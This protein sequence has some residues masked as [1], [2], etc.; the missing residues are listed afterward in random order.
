MRKRVAIAIPLLAPT[1]ESK[2]WED[3]GNVADFTK[4]LLINTAV[5][6]L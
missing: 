1:P 3:P 4:T 5:I 2:L 6:Y